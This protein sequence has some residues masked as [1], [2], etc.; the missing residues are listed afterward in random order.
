MRLDLGHHLR[1][2][3]APRMSRPRHAA[4]GQQDRDVGIRAGLAADH[5][6][7]VDIAV[8]GEPGSIAVS[9][10]DRRR[11][12]DAAHPRRDRLQP[13]HAEREQIA[14]LAGRERV[15]LVDD[16]RAEVLEHRD[17][18]G[19]AQQQRQRFGRGQQDLRRLDPLPRFPIRGRIP[20]ARLDADI[21]THLVDRRQ[22]IALHV[23][24]ERLQ[25]RYIER[26]EP[27][28]RRLDQLGERR[29]EP[30]ERLPRAGRRHQQGMMPR[31]T[32]GQHLQLMPSRP[33][34]PCGKPVFQGEGEV[35]H[36]LFTHRRHMGA[37]RRTAMDRVRNDR[38]FG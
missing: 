24:R 6:D 21:D 36:G 2:G 20:G 14:T 12:R 17:A 22:Q 19:I 28:R 25:R 31:A 8:G 38:H 10:R 3:I 13:R 9:I 34:T 23:D 26:V 11:Q 7:L 35:A 18:V 16:D 4:L 32:L 30:S 27:R 15:D 33:P 1:G 37:S 5:R 29:Q